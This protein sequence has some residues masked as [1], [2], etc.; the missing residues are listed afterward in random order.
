MGD[1]LRGAVCLAGTG[2][3]KVVLRRMMVLDWPGNT[4]LNAFL[5]PL[6]CT[7]IFGLLQWHTN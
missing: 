6:E 5:K 3:I 7:S 1:N 4:L 2:K